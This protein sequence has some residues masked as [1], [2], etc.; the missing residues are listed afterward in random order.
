MSGQALSDARAGESQ[1]T[2]AL[3]A[4]VR[5][6]DSIE[7]MRLD[8]WESRGLTLQQ[9]RV[10]HIIEHEMRAP[11]QVELA[12][13]LGVHSATVTLQLNRLVAMGLVERMRDPVD[14]RARHVVLTECGRR[15]LDTMFHP[16]PAA[17]ARAVA[18]LP[19][20]EVEALTDALEQLS[21]WVRQLA[22]PTRTQHVHPAASSR[23][24]TLPQPPPN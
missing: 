15:V 4:F 22:A 2:R 1:A 6:L 17:I 3:D 7:G 21:E 11:M 10:L 24:M 9:Y 5:L 19:L 23:G 16:V 20:Y 14:R 18:E 12:R 13:R 8:A